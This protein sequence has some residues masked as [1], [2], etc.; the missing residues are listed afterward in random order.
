M[1]SLYKPQGKSKD[2]QNRNVT[3]QAGQMANTTTKRKMN[4]S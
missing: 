3:K 4:D 2:H 1:H